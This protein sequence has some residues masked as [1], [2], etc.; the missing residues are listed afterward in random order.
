M[1]NLTDYRKISVSLIATVF[2]EENNI[3]EF[4]E[5]YKKQSILAEE[6]I[7][8][9]AFS[10]DKTSFLIEEFASNNPNLNI[11]VFKKQSNRSQARNFAVS[12]ANSDYLAFT[13]AGCVL[14]QF[15]LEE[16]LKELTS[17]KEKVVGGFFQG[18]SKNNLEEAMVPYFLQLNKKVNKDNFLPTTRSLLIEKK[19][20]Q[21]MGGLNEKLELS[22]DYQLMLR[23]KKAGV[24]MAFAKKAIVYWLPP[25]SISGFFK[26]ISSFARSDIEAGIIRS[27]V[28]SIFLR[29]L[30]FLIIFLN[31]N[32]IYFFSILS[33]YI[34][35]SIYKNKHNC[36]NSWYY[37]P[38]L[39]ISSDLLIMSA[40]LLALR[41][42]NSRA[43]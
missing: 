37:L 3:K 31:F 35:W 34:F 26:K 13:D 33:L 12:K 32:L 7:I 8:I 23:I 38:F 5:S 21:T 28:L 36:P 9:D 22:E 1:S 19:L 4:L 39:Q 17:S 11:R 29:Y 43:F 18:V 15:W 40:S 16:L 41:K 20:W 6:F 2:N 25:K 10:S 14:D 42:F 27:K 30:I 24:K